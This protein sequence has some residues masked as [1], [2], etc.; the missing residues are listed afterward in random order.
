MKATIVSL[1]PFP[2]SRSFPGCVPESFTVPA[3]LDKE[4]PAIFIMPD[5]KFSIYVDSD[6][7]PIK[8][9]ADALQAANS[10][11]HDFKMGQFLVDLGTC[12]PGLFAVEGEHD[13]ES[14]RKNFP[15]E[16]ARAYRNQT[17]WFKKNVS[18][19]DD[20]WQRFRRR[21]MISN[22]CVDA[23]R[24]LGLNREWIIDNEIDAAAI[25]CPVCFSTVNANAAVCGSCRA[26]LRPE[27]LENIQ[28]LG[29][30][31]PTATPPATGPTPAVPQK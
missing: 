29:Q 22:L 13:V 15:G 3:S 24:W 23:A 12:E 21:S 31:G 27:A 19:A 26:I 14:I 8:Q 20:L 1:V 2:V 9:T 18:H 10:L 4:T 6:R 25:K 17:E 30:S 5:V 11:C 7:P 16:L 28:F